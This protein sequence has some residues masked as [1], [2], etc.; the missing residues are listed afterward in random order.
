[1]GWLGNG[2]EVSGLVW[3]ARLAGASPGVLRYGEVGYVEARQA[4]SGK[5]CCGEVSHGMVRRGMAGEVRLGGF[6]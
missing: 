3:Q 1:M 4:G 2:V 6:W 5:V